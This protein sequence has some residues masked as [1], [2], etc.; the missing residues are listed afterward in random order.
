MGTN[1]T[2][3]R[4]TSRTA[5]LKQNRMDTPYVANY[6]CRIVKQG[7]KQKGGGTGNLVGVVERVQNRD[8]MILR[9]ARVVDINR[10]KQA[11]C[12]YNVQ[13]AES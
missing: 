8:E 6:F 7:T 1:K 4:L 11:N 9:S 12:A 2:D 13:F 3:E 5:S 10:S